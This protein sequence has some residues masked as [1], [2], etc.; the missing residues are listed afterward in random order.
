[1]KEPWLQPVSDSTKAAKTLTNP[2]FTIFFIV[3]ESLMFFHY[4][5]RGK[6]MV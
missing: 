2:N 5:I 6:P 3:A 1:M 4:N